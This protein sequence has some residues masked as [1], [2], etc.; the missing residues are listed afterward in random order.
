MRGIAF[1]FYV[2]AILYVLAGMLFGIH[3]AG[4][5]DFSL[6]P[7]HAHLNL[8]G[9]VTT[10][11]FGIYYHVVPKAAEGMLPKVHFAVAT[12]GV[13]LMFPGIIM[14]IQGQGEALAIIGSLL[15]ILSMLIFLF[16]VIRS[17]GTA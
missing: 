12:P 9:W 2:V 15:T 14:S 3:M 10:G 16:T 17:R 8:V 1:L 6:A 5:H 13:I 11:M 7:A 4:A